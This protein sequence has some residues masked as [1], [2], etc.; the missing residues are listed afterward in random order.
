[1]TNY[2]RQNVLFCFDMCI[3]Y[4]HIIDCQGG[5]YHNRLPC[6]N[7]PQPELEDK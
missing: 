2:D 6:Y 4:I 5:L 1:M 3:K 7:D